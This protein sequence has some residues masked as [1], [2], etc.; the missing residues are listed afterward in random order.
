MLLP[1]QP[2]MTTCDNNHSVAIRNIGKTCPRRKNRVGVYG[3]FKL[4][5]PCDT[6]ARRKGKNGMI[7]RVLF[8]Y[9]NI[10]SPF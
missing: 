1:S 5:E 2:L 9:L 7:T 6:A 8:S 10:V 3:A 4:R